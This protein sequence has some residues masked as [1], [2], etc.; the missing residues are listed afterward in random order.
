MSI[1][2]KWLN[3]TANNFIPL[4]A[5]LELTYRCNERCTHCYIEKFWDDPK[6]VLTINQWE[7]ILDELKSAGTLY[8]ILM[9]GEA[10]LNPLFWDIVE[11]AQKRHFHISMIT[12]GLKIPTNETAQRLKNLGV[13]NMTISLYSIYPEVHDAMTQVKGSHEKTLN[14]IKF[15][16]E[17]GIKVGINCLLTKNNI[18]DYMKLALWCV[19]EDLE[20]KVDP[21]VTAKLNGD[22]APTFLRASKDQLT[23]H[24]QLIATTWPRGVSRPTYEKGSD[25][26]CNAAKGKCAVNPYGELLSCIEIRKS[27]GNL[28]T[29]SFAEAWN[30]D[31]ANKWRGITNQT[32]KGSDEATRAFCEHCPGMAL[33][34]LK[35][36]LQLIEHTVKVATVKKEIYE[37]YG[38]YIPQD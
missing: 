2:D 37:K 24:Y 26:V 20:M 22:L 3:K 38:K 10:M 25:Y 30:S 11:Q 12:N 31:E 34:E 27:L 1:V 7:K 32:V 28:V 19:Q 16:R 23:N 5:S 29:Q 15:S 36:P 17:A 35:D 9:G 4:Q 6:K 8:L 33:N 21:N 18:D 13:K 14:A